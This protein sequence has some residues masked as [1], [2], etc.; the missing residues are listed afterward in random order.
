[1]EKG[2]SFSLLVGIQ[3]VAAPVESSM[4]IPQKLKMDLP[5]DPAIPLL[6]MYP[7]E[8]KTLIRKNIS[9]PM[10]T[11]ALFEVVKIWKPPKCL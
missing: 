9:I 8:L 6:G 11:E 5:F 4:E 7:K 2:E 3:I 10:F 1:M